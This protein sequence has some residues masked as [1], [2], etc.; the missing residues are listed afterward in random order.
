M[1][2]TRE[3]TIVEAIR[4]AL[5][6]EMS[7]DPT[8]FMMGE[9]IGRAG[10]VF[11]VTAGLQDEFGKDRVMDT[12]ISEAGFT[13]LGVGAA[14]T[15][16]RPVVEILFC[17]FLT[18]AM[19]QIVNQAAKL[20]YMTGGQAKVPLVVRTLMG[21]GRGAAAQHSQS[22]QAW[23]A[24]VPGL[25]VVMPSTPYDA[26]GLLKSAIRD[27]NPVIFMEDKMSY[28]IKGPV[29]TG[30]YTIPLG[31]ADVKRTGTDVTLVATSSMVQVALSAADMLAQDAPGISAEVVDPRTLKPL[32]KET[33]LE[34][35]KK[36]GR[37]VVIDEGH[38]SYGVTAEIAAIIAD[39]AFD[40]LDAP[41]KRLGAMDVPVPMMPILEKAT[42]PNEQQLVAI[43]K[44]LFG[45]RY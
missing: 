43:A 28:Q 33:I 10:G 39:E 27:D 35:V 17:D 40:Y 37:A 30:D 34:S 22:L 16:M 20:H 3:M 25:K 31:L 13:G 24:H 8:V 41:V 14:L 29:P 4:E 21:A 7:R 9:D 18:L 1:P 26:K 42:V 36:T 12:P 23:V 38:L 44:G 15:G 45:R 6:E 19:D 11:N 2:D 32:D 5:A